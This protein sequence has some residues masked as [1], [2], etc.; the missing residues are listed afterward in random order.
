MG[1]PGSSFLASA[2]ESVD[3]LHFSLSWCSSISLSL[4]VCCFS[5]WAK[6]PSDHFCHFCTGPP[7]RKLGQNLDEKIKSGPVR[8]ENKMCVAKLV[9]CRRQRI[10]EKMRWQIFGERQTRSGGGKQL[11]AVATAKSKEVTTINHYQATSIR[12]E[13]GG[14]WWLRGE[15][16]QIKG[17]LIDD[18]YISTTCYNQYS[19]RWQSTILFWS[20]NLCDRWRNVN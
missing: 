12:G 3:M 16:C 1:P 19:I 11:A 5:I 2:S 17:W 7:P 13:G 10:N 18:N 9:K 8:T 20:G 4:F 14:R 15:D 6:A